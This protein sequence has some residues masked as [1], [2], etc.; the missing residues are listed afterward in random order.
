MIKPAST[1]IVFRLAAAPKDRQTR[2]TGYGGAV[3]KH[4][5]GHIKN[6][7]A[8]IARELRTCHGV[9]YIVRR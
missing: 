6:E 2:I 1:S 7:A 5:A 3:A 8:Q 4:F 9:A